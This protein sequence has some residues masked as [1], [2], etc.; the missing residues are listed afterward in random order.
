MKSNAFLFLFFIVAINGFGQVVIGPKGTKL[1]L[2]SSKWKI[3]GNNIYNKNAGNLGIGTS[4]PS[5]QLHTTGD[6]RLE[7][8]GSN[9][10]NSKILTADDIGNIT[11]RSLS[12]MLSGNTITSINGLTSSLQTFLNGTTGSDFNIASSGSTH[13]FN[14]PNASATTRGALSSADWT[15]FNGKENALNFSG[16]LIRNL[17]TIS[18]STTQNISALSNLTANGLIKTS[19]GTGLLSIAEAS[20][21]PIL[22][23]NTTGSAATVIT[24]ANL[25]G[26]I[27]SVGNTTSVEANVITNSMLS[28]IPTQV[29]KGR[30]SA[31]NGNVEDLTSTQATAM[32]NTF[33]SSEKG[34]VPA[35]G[36]GTTTFLRA[37]GNFASPTGNAY[38][39]L[40]TITSD[41][42]NNNAI[43]NSLED[44]TGLSFNVVSGT[45][46]RFYAIIPYTS[47]AS[48]NG[49]RWTITA[50]SSSLLHYTSRYTASA[51]SE[52]VNHA[53]AINIPAACN[54]N[55][56]LNGNLAIIEG[57][58]NPTANGTVQIR[59][60]SETANVAITA[61]AG[62]TLEY[63]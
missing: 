48:N 50:P 21:F 7:G 61:K 47:A 8:L 38:R 23:Q 10:T 46:Y 1:T 28:Q 5:A 9:T 45:T 20:D 44:V 49:S 33:N 26:P 51:T 53:G 27:T 34:L 22:N 31:G 30:T 19:G 36:G 29:F 6:L 58:I 15:I 3:S 52:T 24:N 16:G 37:D 35:S 18:L 11:T 4:T 17:N 13:T 32:L 41:V 25:T 39:N 60:A 57:V 63:W 54:N 43:A 12:N 42:I 40:V 14:L 59:F 56:I 2:D 55:S 62:A